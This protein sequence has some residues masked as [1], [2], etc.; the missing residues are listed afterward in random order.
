MVLSSKRSV[1]KPEAG[2]S[3]LFPFFV[4]VDAN[5]AQHQLFRKHL[6]AVAE[7]VLA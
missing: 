4:A 2:Y 6:P 3:F 1:N 7:I 5:I